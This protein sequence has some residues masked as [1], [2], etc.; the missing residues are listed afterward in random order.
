M[1]LLARAP[2]EHLPGGRHYRP[3]DT[4]ELDGKKQEAIAREL[5]ASGV[6]D[7]ACDASRSL[8]A[9]MAEEKA[10]AAREAAERAEV[11]AK[12][13]AEAQAKA[14]AEAAERAESEAAKAKKR[15]G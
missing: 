1:K 14:E 5:L 11:E 2:I 6:A 10:A 15:G 13:A 7:A 3:A 12:A 8:V 9:R 4:L